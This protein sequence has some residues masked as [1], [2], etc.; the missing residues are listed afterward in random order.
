MACR[1]RSRMACRERSRKGSMIPIVKVDEEAE[2]KRKNKT[3]PWQEARLCLVHK[4]GS[5]TATFGATFSGTVA[6]AGKQLYHC[7]VQAG[8]G[9]KTQLHAVGDGATWIADQI[10]LQFGAQGRYLIDFYHICDYLAAAAKTCAPK[11]EKAWL[12]QQKDLLKHNDYPS[13]LDELDPFLEADTIEVQ[14]AP[15]YQKS[16]SSVR[17]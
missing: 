16:P 12:D 15:V 2:D 17:L 11:H 1:E 4:A 13:V 14:S 9:N 8:F 7:A 5:T 10:D 6:D 3:L